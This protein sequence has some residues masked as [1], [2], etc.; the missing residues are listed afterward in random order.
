[1][2][3]KEVQ[4]FDGSAGVDADRLMKELGQFR[5]FHL[6]NYVLL[7]IPVYVAALYATNYVFLAA[8]VPYRCLIPECELSNSTEFK[9]SWVEG[10]LPAESGRQQRCYRRTLS[11]QSSPDDHGGCL[12]EMFSD[13]LQPCEQWLYASRDTIVSEFNLAC[14]EWKRTLVGTVHNI[15][16]LVSLPILGYISDRWGRKR[17]LV[18][19]CTLVGAIG[20]LKA[21]SISYEMYIIIEFLETVAGASAFPAAYILTIELLGQD[22]RVLTTAFQGIMLVLGGLSFALLAKTF[23]Y[24]RTF[25]MV[26]YP[27]SLL[28]LLY[29]YL[30][31]E[32]IRWLLSKGRKEEAVEIIMKAAKMNKVTLS[33]ETM[34]QLTEEKTKPIDEKKN[35]EEES[36]LWMQVLRSPII[37][38]RLAICS[39]WWIT[40]T[41]VFYGLAIN[42]VSLAGDKYTNY[43]L[44]VSVEVIA[45]VT[46]ALVLDRIG[47]KRTLLSAYTV[48]G[49]ACIAIAFVPKTLSWLSTLLYLLGKIAITQAFSGVYMYT[50]ELFPTHARHSLLGFCSMVGRIGSIVAPQMPLLAIYVEWLPSV[51]FGSAALVA[52]GLM[53]TTPETLNTRLP[54]TIKEAEQI[55]HQKKPTENIQM[56]T[57]NQTAS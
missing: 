50:S 53:L 35:P 8:D 29:I 32:S 18:L 57:T 55:A 47:R 42:S 46:N 43:M 44:V 41:F 28:F 31:P 17:A 45:V 5:L 23:S 9:P 48:C 24:W 52:G 22:K 39:W 10:A 36:G 26:V 27:P 2:E 14:Q 15:G 54:D 13:Q 20:S 3:K 7:F 25:I 1:M 51:L 6:F 37:M 12:Q 49:I 56:N 38:T 34:K 40:C 19:S 4:S 30:L 33:E 11:D 16:M 21:F